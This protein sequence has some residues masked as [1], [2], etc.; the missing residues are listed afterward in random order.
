MAAFVANAGGQQSQHATTSALRPTQRALVLLELMLSACGLAGGVY[1]AVRPLDAMPVRYLEGTWFAT[2]R[3]PGLALIFFVGICPALAAIAQMRHLPVALVG[4]LC[5]GTGTVAWILLE[6]S[7]IV[8]SPPM[9]I[10]VGLV[11]AVILTLAVA[12]AVR[13]RGHTSEPLIARHLR[14]PGPN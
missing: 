8:V 2:W 5:V 1:L 3:W 4:H 7:W 10:F 6:A 12:E 14:R 13:R 11:G 9:Q